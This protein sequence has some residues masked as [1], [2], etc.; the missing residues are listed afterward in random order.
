M[1]DLE[2]YIG[3]TSIRMNG[4][5]DFIHYQE[6]QIT[7]KRKHPFWKLDLLSSSGET[8]ETPSLLG[9]LGR[10]NFRH[11]S[12]EPILGQTQSFCNYAVKGQA[13]V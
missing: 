11:W 13:V 4:Y 10:A 9:V 7:K 2:E 1:L 12:S 3:R 5:M 6:L 8:K